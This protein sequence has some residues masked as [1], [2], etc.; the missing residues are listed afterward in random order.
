MK[1]PFIVKLETEMKYQQF[2]Q[3]A[4]VDRLLQQGQASRLGIRDRLGDLLIRLGSKRHSPARSDS[5]AS[6]FG[7]K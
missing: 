2:L 3:E 6:V 1:H 4:A 5:P 7:A